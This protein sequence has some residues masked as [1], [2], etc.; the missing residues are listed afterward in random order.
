MKTLINMA[1]K[2]GK[3]SSKKSFKKWL[4]KA[5]RREL[6]INKYGIPSEE[7]RRIMLEK[8]AK[9]LRGKMTAPEKKMEVLLKEMGIAHDTQK[10]LGDFIY[11]FYIPE[12]RLL[13]E[14]DGDYFHG[15]PSKYA[16][17]ELNHLQKK[18]K[19]NDLLK[20]MTA[21]GTRHELL[22]FWECDINDDMQKIRET[23]LEHIKKDQK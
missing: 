13:I 16:N 1:K 18:N 19:R 2:T 21:K 17:D 6:A 4:E 23:I 20:N 14:V 8:N 12:H 7:E 22:R 11:D 15:N 9:K 5:K 10:V 3:A